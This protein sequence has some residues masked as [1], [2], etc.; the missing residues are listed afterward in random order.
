MLA[1]SMM[2]ILAGHCKGW[3]AAFCAARAFFPLAASFLISCALPAMAEENGHLS[4]DGNVVV[5]GDDGGIAH[6]VV[7]PV[8][9]DGVGSI[10]LGSGD[11]FMVA[12]DN[13]VQVTG[14]GSKLIRSG[15]GDVR[16]LVG[17]G[18]NVGAED[19]L[20]KP[21]AVA[22]IHKNQPAV[23]TSRIYPTFYGEFFA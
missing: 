21:L 5:G 20:G 22:Q 8:I 6:A 14:D 18:R 1:W 11:T 3:P 17:L 19:H 9:E 4:F 13:Y 15:K 23:V 10:D 12:G 2:D 7:L 16:V